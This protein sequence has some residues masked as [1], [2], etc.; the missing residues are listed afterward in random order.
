MD[1]PSLPAQSAQFWLHDRG[2]GPRR[3]L[4]GSQGIDDNTAQ[5]VVE[6]F[7]P[8]SVRF[9]AT[10]PS[11]FSDR[12]A[13]LFAW[14]GPDLA[15]LLAGLDC[16][17][18]LAA[19]DLGQT[20]G[21]FARE[22]FA[23]TKVQR[24]N[25][26]AIAIVAADRVDLSRQ[27]AAARRRLLAP[28]GSTEAQEWP[29]ETV[30]LNLEPIGPGAGLAFV[31]PAMGNGFAG[32]GREIAVQW[33]H[34]LRRQDGENE[35]LQ[36]Q[37]EPGVGWNADMPERFEDHR[38]PIFGQVTIGT[39]VADLLR[40][41]GVEPSASIGYSLGES[42]ALFGLR[43]WTARDAM[44]RKFAGSSLFATDLAGPCNAA[45]ATWGLAE[46]EAVDW[47]AAIVA[48]SADQVRAAIRGIDRA[49]LL[50]VNT[51]EECVIGGASGAVAEVV[52]RL[53]GKSWPLPTVSTVH[54]EIVRAVEAAYRDLH[55]LPT[56]APAGITFYS[57]ASG[58]PYS[59]SEDSA[60]D[61]ILAQA[62]DT[63]DFPD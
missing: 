58:A 40:S 45:R 31:F 52:A 33:P 32:M 17:V 42:T 38:A 62:L 56:V 47:V 21:P 41:F 24:A 48:N 59:L 11:P 37:M 26:L 13:G 61:A 54:C 55:V 57:G 27:V 6:A 30:A 22:W 5:I 25:E 63:V 39:V 16:L 12:P 43:A 46:G 10:Q 51:D 7:E 20:I 23:S 50:L 1:E 4:V 3:A 29:G 44:Y 28:V 36:S 18:A 14:S 19:R 34:V 2:V 53:G 8:P 15:A 9:D 49:Y 35:L 60:A